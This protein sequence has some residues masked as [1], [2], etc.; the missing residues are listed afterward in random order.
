MCSTRNRESGRDRLVCSVELLDRIDQLGYL[1]EEEGVG[2]M[3]AVVSELVTAVFTL[4]T[5]SSTS[6]DIAVLG[7][8][9]VFRES[10]LA[11]L[12]GGIVSRRMDYPG[13]HRED[14]RSLDPYITTPFNRR[15]SVEELTRQLMT[16]LLPP[17][18]TTSSDGKPVA[19]RNDSGSATVGAGSTDENIGTLLS[20]DHQAFLHERHERRLEGRSKRPA[21]SPQNIVHSDLGNDNDGGERSEGFT[22]ESNVALIVPPLS[23]PSTSPLPVIARPQTPPHSTSFRPEQATLHAS[24]LPKRVTSP[25]PT[26]PSSPFSSP[27]ILPSPVSPP[28]S[29]RSTSP[30]QSS[31]SPSLSPSSS[32]STNSTVKA[33]TPPLTPLLPPKKASSFL[34]VAEHK[35]NKAF[36]GAAGKPPSEVKSVLL[37]PSKR[38]RSCVDE[39]GD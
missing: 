6:Q 16:M 14:T 38:G 10:S 9:L 20:A 29:T 39:Q 21:L 33:R 8:A 22:E 30:T 17:L 4:K 35:H 31:P 25:T 15:S 24:P 27:A 11:G 28:P 32:P 5:P 36:F 13:R 2:D 23:P 19:Q 1:E 34:R 37:P 18:P 3:A 7:D 26:P 12:L